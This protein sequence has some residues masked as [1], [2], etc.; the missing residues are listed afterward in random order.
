MSVSLADLRV[1][2]GIAVV[3]ALLATSALVGVVA[4]R[5]AVRELAITRSRAEAVVDSA[6]DAVIVT[7]AAGRIVTLWNPAAERLYGWA[8]EEVVGR[9]LPTHAVADDAARE[10]V[11]E[12]VRHGERVAVVARRIRKDGTEIDVRVRYSA[13][14]DD[15]GRVAELMGLVTDV[16]A[17]QQAAERAALVERLAVVVGD[18]NADLEIDAVLD[19][20]VS[21][22]VDLLG[23]AGASLVLA[24]DDRPTVVA[25]A[26]SLG[27]PRGHRFEA[28]RV[29]LFASVPAGHPAVVNDY[30]SQPFRNAAVGP[31][32]TLLAASVRA[33]SELLGILAV[34]FRD[35]DHEVSPAEREV[36]ELLARHA[37]TAYANAR[38]YARMAEAR[39]RVQAVLDALADGVAVLDATGRVT[40]WN[41]AAAALTAVGADEIVGSPLPWDV[42]DPHE[43]A[44][45]R[46]GDGH[47]VELAATPLAT[48]GGQV[49]AL[50]DVSRHKALEQA[51]S[52]FLASTGHELKTPLTVV[53]GYA[54]L[55]EQRWDT[56][57]PEDRRAG[58]EAISRKAAALAQTVEQIMLFSVA[59]AGRHDLAVRPMALGRIIADAVAGVEETASG[60]RIVVDVP[61]QLPDVA[62]DPHRLTT[63]VAQ[64]VENA[65]KY[66][67]DGGTVTVS[68]RPTEGQEVI[69]TVADEGIGFVPAE[70]EALFDRFTRGRTGGA[71][72]VGLGLSIVRSLVEAH[73]GRV[74]ADGT[75]GEGARFS[76]T[77]PVA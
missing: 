39:T 60:H 8:A 24:V 69:V 30:Q 75:P 34:Y 3:I 61:P 4:L 35:A 32:G 45:A 37:G 13:L 76:F 49:V 12:R 38:S 63:V 42:G 1:E 44:L 65:V 77:V 56:L 43:P 62:G 19:R 20:I 2:P 25:N 16:T 59:E 70:A 7:D 64:L 6:T 27:A 66:S 53:S 57:A 74:W 47:W 71:S 23:A 21:G 55:L 48:G 41:A 50:R 58:I 46:V 18:L 52:V 40:S 28:A 73:G 15:H 33:G 26:G 72:G 11:L 14:R 51:K 29:E 68:A 10:E 5:R 36:A 17:E 31:V 54:R 22:A 9:R 67:P